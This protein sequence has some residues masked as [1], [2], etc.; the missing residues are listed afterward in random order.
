MDTGCIM[1][2]MHTKKK[3]AR[4]PS[5]AQAIDVRNITETY[6][7]V[8]KKILVITLVQAMAWRFAE[9]GCKLVLVRPASLVPV[10]AA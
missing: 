3:V 5:S 10:C 7:S 6:A 1:L 9:L 4:H 8:F 2:D